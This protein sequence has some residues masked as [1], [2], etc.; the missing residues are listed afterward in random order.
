[1]DPTFHRQSGPYAFGV[2]SYCILDGGSDNAWL[3]GADQKSTPPPLSKIRSKADFLDN[4]IGG[5][6]EAVIH[7]AITAGALLCP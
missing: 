6:S 4:A 1:M 7:G 5:A 2:F 3:R